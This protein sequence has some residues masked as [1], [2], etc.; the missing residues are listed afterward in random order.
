[1]APDSYDTS[2]GVGRH[3]WVSSKPTHLG[4]RFGRSDE[5]PTLE[6]QTLILAQDR[7]QPQAIREVRPPP[8]RRLDDPVFGL[9]K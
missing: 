2:L 3:Q 8:R 1:V 7:M 6:Q 5:L 4:H 9:L